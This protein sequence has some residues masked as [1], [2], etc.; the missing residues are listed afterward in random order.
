MYSAK[1]V[2]N[3]EKIV[4]TF[5]H[6]GFDVVQVDSQPLCK[7]NSLCN[8][9]I[10]LMILLFSSCADGTNLDIITRSAYPVIEIEYNWESVQGDDVSSGIYAMFFIS[11]LSFAFLA[12]GACTN[13]SSELAKSLGGIKS[14]SGGAGSVMKRQNTF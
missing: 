11:L 6:D 14:S 4:I 12:Y 13:V 1:D 7:N 9:S 2:S 10:K 8:I 3:M 5:V